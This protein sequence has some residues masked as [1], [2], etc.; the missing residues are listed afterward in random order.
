MLQS[1]A[2]DGVT[3]S[4]LELSV[5]ETEQGEADAVKDGASDRISSNADG[6]EGIA[7]PMRQCTRELCDFVIR[8]ER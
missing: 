1:R 3:P 7:A 2:P 8:T 4:R 5:S 6:V